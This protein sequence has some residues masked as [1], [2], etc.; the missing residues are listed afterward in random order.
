[1]KARRAHYKVAQKQLE[2]EKEQLLR[3]KL[4]DAKQ[5]TELPA[6]DRSGKRARAPAQVKQKSVGA[7]DTVLGS[8]DKL[9]ELEKRIS[10]LE[11]SNVYD[12]FR[13]AK[14]GATESR[15]R[16]LPPH[17]TSRRTSGGTHQDSVSK[18]RSGVQ[19]PGAGARGHR[20]SFSKQK[21][22]ATV[23]SP[24]QVYYS[25]RVRRR[26]GSA[27][28]DTNLARK[29]RRRGDDVRIHQRSGA[30]A[31]NARAQRGPS[32][33][34][35]Q[36]PNV[37]RYTR[38]GMGRAGPEFCREE[39]RGTRSAVA[40]KKR[41][42]AKRRIAG[43]RAEAMR[44]ARQDRII[45]EWMQ[46]KRAA[47]VIENRQRTSSHL[48][49]PR[50]TAAGVRVRRSIGQGS[51]SASVVRSG[52]NSNIH[53]REFRDIRAQYTKRTERLRRDLAR[54]QR[55]PEAGAFWAGT[56]TSTATRPRPGPSMP[57]LPSHPVRMSRQRPSLARKREVRRRAETIAWRRGGQEQDER[58]RRA[59]RVSQGARLAVGGTGLRAARARQ[60]QRD[61]R[62]PNV[63]GT[64]N[65]IGNGVSGP[66]WGSCS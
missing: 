60:S 12:D 10:S 57:A 25:V 50:G 52:R 18:T 3:G 29:G 8:L 53:L 46:R 43:Q 40:E 15:T 39:K 41:L 16:A 56:R 30:G 4:D 51:A 58:G 5:S 22:E 47:A 42:E 59:R 48:S 45:R 7:L 36:L 26:L 61:T 14:Q 35:T 63:R 44:V 33:F 62:L 1:M 20:L 32:T 6:S 13:A 49:G 27:L 11:K 54:K 31:V 19:R 64:R 28:G 9:V 37:H 24:S 21:S 65:R 38:A 17:A 66:R 2:I 34:L 55:G 23:E